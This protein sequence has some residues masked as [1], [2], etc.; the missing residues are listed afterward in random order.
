MEGKSL[1]LT[2][3]VDGKLLL[4][5]YALSEFALSGFALS[6]FENRAFEDVP[7][8]PTDFLEIGASTPPAYLVTLSFD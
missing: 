5:L 6:G 2:W 4:L 8:F 3:F 7:G 1:L